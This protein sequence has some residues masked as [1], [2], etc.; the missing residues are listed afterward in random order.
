MLGG[1]VYQKSFARGR[2]ID[3]A[4][5]D[6]TWLTALKDINPRAVMVKDGAS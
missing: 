1:Y 4:L 6:V 5:M 3:H 2:L